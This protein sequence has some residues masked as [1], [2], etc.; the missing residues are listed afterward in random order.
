MHIPFYTPI[1]CHQETPGRQ[2]GVHCRA[3]AILREMVF[4]SQ[5]TAVYSG[6]DIACTVGCLQECMKLDY[7]WLQYE[8]LVDLGFLGENYRAY[9]S[10][11][12]LYFEL[13]FLI[14]SV[15]SQGELS[16]EGIMEPAQCQVQNPQK[17]LRGQQTLAMSYRYNLGKVEEP[18]CIEDELKLDVN[19]EVR[20][21]L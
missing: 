11:C 3:E 21:G 15:K 1:V 8:G 9:P 16:L 12:L 2:G 4:Q 18:I 17:C 13:V 5:L 10:F 20:E 7:P 19:M 6:M 14:S